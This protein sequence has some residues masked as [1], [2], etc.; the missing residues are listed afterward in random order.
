MYSRLSDQRFLDIDNG[1]SYA[2]D[3]GLVGLSIQTNSVRK[4]S[5]IQCNAAE[6]TSQ[7][8]SLA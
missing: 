5:I 4:K 8:I 3:A 2:M 7:D 1:K 6:D